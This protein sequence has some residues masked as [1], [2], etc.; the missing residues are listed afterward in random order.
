[1]ILRRRRLRLKLAAPVLQLQGH[2][3]GDR[4]GEIELPDNRLQIGQAA[5]ERVDRHDVPVA[6]GGQL[7][8]SIV[9]SSLGPPVGGER[10]ANPVGFNPQ[11]KLKAEAKIVARFR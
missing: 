1:M 2:E 10:L 5:G 3:A 7:K 9:A 6:G 4:Y 11:S 8:Y